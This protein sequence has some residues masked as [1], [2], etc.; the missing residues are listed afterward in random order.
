MKK[1]I[2]SFINEI[3]KKEE[4]RL[5]FNIFKGTAQTQEKKLS[6]SDI[7]TIS[8]VLTYIKKN[9][10]EDQYPEIWGVS[11]KI[12]E[13]TSE[14]N[15]EDFKSLYAN[16]Y[17]TTQEGLEGLLN[18]KEVIS[19]LK[20]ISE[21][22]RSKLKQQSKKESLQFFTEIEKKVRQMKSWFSS[23][24]VKQ[25]PKKNIFIATFYLWED[26]NI[27]KN[28]R[29][30]DDAA[31]NLFK[32]FVI[33]IPFIILN[34]IKKEIDKST[35][36]MNLETFINKILAGEDFKTLQNKDGTVKNKKYLFFLV[37]LYLNQQNLLDY[38]TYLNKTHYKNR[39]KYLDKYFEV[40]KT[41]KAEKEKLIKMFD[42][43][44]SKNM[45]FKYDKNVESDV[46]LS[47]L[48][49]RTKNAENELMRYVEFNKSLFLKQMK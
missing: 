43:Y 45:T 44:W 7:Q 39:R 48:L 5:L 47:I 30:K 49:D 28:V 18:K 17:K 9:F 11:L 46:L 42:E 33:L 35:K 24:E 29:K 32:V 20:N 36:E 3:S 13:D 26:A 1:N 4:Y 12:K 10:K 38:D 16:T 19:L 6:G 31:F 34:E 25:I 23:K 21:S 27:F 14:S 40:N 8:T 41:T 37:Q 15:N 2:N 22:D